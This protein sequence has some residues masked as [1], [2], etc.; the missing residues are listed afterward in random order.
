MK[1][2]NASVLL[3]SSHSSQTML[4]IIT[5]SPKISFH[6][7]I[8]EMPVELCGNDLGFIVQR[9]Q[10][11]RAISK[12]TQS[13]RSRAET[14]PHPSQAPAVETGSMGEEIRP[15]CVS[16]A[17]GLILRDCCHVARI[18]G[19][20]ER[21]C[22]ARHLTVINARNKKRPKEAATIYIYPK[23]SKHFI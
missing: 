11:V 19:C 23:Q 4:F 20:G 8:H 21:E 3:F 2:E 7:N 15:Y 1:A 9:A 6:H 16:L 5:S 17:G 13:L 22:A 14:S 12:C 18:M 10:R